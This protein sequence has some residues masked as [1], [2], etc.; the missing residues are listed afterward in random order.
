MVL[1]VVKKNVKYNSLT[2]NKKEKIMVLKL[3]VGLISTSLSFWIRHGFKSVCV[4]TGLTNGGPSN[5]FYSK[6]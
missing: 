3:V 6:I 5:L 4:H 1:Y 2:S